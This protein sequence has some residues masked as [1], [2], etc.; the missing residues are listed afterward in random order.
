M[1]I[2]SGLGGKSRSFL[3]LI[4]FFA[5]IV[6]FG[7]YKID[8]RYFEYSAILIT[9]FLISL[10]HS[11]L[12]LKHGTAKGTI[13]DRP[14]EVVQLI[15]KEARDKRTIIFTHDLGLTYAL[16]EAKNHRQW[17]VCSTYLDYIH[18]IP[19]AY[20]PNSFVPQMV[21]VIRSYIGPLRKEIKPL[22][23]A[24]TEAQNT[25]A[26]LEAA[27]LSKDRDIKLK[28]MVPGVN[29]LTNDLPEFRFE[30]VYGPSKSNIDW[31]KVASL[32]KAPRYDLWAN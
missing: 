14:E 16:N 3:I 22:N 25:I 28:K 2:L 12:L 26:V 21:F 6:S 11:N 10:G 31:L 19:K 30:V 15:T 23:K 17:I 7:I 9:I 20:L 24:L 1:G 18:N 27:H 5:F 8:N 29:D 4:P 32:F 13:N